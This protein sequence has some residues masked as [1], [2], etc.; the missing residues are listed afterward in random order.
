[1]KKHY[2]SI[3]Y[4]CAA[5]SL[6]LTSCNKKT[7]DVWDN[8][9]KAGQYKD[10]TSSLWGN[11]EDLSQN[12]ELSSFDNE[13]FIPLNEEDLKAAFA[14]GAISQPKETPG[15]IGSSL[16]N[17]V[18]FQSPKNDLSRLFV[19][20]YFDTD[21]HILRGKESLMALERIASYLNENT[22]IS[23]VIEGHC[24]ER[25]PEAYNLSLGTR[26]ANYIRS[27]LVQKGVDLNRLHTISYGKERPASSG[28]NQ[29]SWK[30]NRRAQFK[31]F[32]KS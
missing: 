25:G 30:E 20:L 6:F 11:S 15:D 14:D 4:V 5:A 10:K 24:D 21:D 26:R 31:I 16:P 18:E 9:P 19:T 22:G 28:H 13:E 32:N 12:D 2:L 1:M 17:V 8:Q 27:M 7:S 23:L 29:L 3:I